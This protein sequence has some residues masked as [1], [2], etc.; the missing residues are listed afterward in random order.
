MA[1]AVGDLLKIAAIFPIVIRGGICYFL[2][3]RIEIEPLCKTE[4]FQYFVKIGGNLM[5][6]LSK[7]RKWLAGTVGMAL[8][9]IILAGIG[10]LL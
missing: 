3:C 1:A 8:I 5:Q 9:S 7:C 2:N 10:M 4:K 6:C